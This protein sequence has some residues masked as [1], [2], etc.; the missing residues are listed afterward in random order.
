MQSTELRSGKERT[1][2]TSP[3][4]ICL[5]TSCFPAAL[6]V[7]KELKRLSIFLTKTSDHAGRLHFLRQ[8]IHEKQQAFV[9]T[10]WKVHREPGTCTDAES[11]GSGRN[12]RAD[13][14]AERDL[15]RPTANRTPGPIGGYLRLNPEKTP[16]L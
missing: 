6:I 9:R 10:V 13:G 14:P 8:E 1:A 5:S 3:E 2:Q 12:E 7:K 16:H 4:P 15:W 11:D